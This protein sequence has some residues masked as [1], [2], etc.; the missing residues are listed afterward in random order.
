M[1]DGNLRK[2]K[3]IV[4]LNYAAFRVTIKLK[5]NYNFNTN[6]YRDSNII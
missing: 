2:N 4:L 3:I 6:D 1:I 5:E